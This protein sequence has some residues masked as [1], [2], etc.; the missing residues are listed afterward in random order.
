MKNYIGVKRIKASAMN[1][2]QYN[3]YR[4]WELPA[5]E[6]G[7]DEGFLVEYIDGGQSNH[8]AHSGYI[9]WSPKEVFEQ[10]YSEE[11]HELTSTK[12][13]NELPLHQLRVID[14]AEELLV[15]IT[16]LGEFI[17]ESIIYENL[18]EEEQLRLRSQFDAMDC[19]HSILV[20]RIN[21][22]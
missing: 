10:A 20:S 21:K 22:F 18:D 12:F 14:E 9:S 6:N 3:D 15:K 16:A 11:T 17:N 5:D 2:Q 1:R 19:Y 4:G 13:T 8:P 7:S